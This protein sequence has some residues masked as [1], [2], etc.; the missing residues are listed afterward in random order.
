MKVWN[1]MDPSRY[2]LDFIVF[3]RKKLS[4]IAELSEVIF[5]AD[6]FLGTVGRTFALSDLPYTVMG[7]TYIW[8]NRATARD[9][10]SS[11]RRTRVSNFVKFH[12]NARG[13]F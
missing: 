8:R 13:A 1:S 7:V 9:L 10:L 12:V 4:T 5:R 2:A 11:G 6:R 3:S